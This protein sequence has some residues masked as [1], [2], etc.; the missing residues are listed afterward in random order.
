MTHRLFT[1]L[2]LVLVLCGTL[3][4]EKV[5]STI[6]CGK[7]EKQLTIDIA[8][9]PGHMLSLT[10]TTC[11]YTAGSVGGVQVKEGTGAQFDDM[12]GNHSDFHGY[13]SETYENGDK[14]FYR[15]QG[16]AKLK[17]GAVESGKDNWTVLGGTGK[18]KGATGKGTCTETGGAGGSVT[19][20]CEGNITVSK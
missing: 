16:T 7:P 1:V 15:Y 8:D 12:R 3:V 11:S 19:W 4:A 20:H 10:E 9:A 14:A 13:W 17:D 2:G 5:S 18:M 6:Q